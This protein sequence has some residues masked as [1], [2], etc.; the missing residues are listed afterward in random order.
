M[1]TCFLYV[2]TAYDQ[3]IQHAAVYLILLKNLILFLVRE[4]LISLSCNP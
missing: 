4:L 2:N 3:E 1:A